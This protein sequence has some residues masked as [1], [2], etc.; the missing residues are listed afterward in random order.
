MRTLG[1]VPQQNHLGERAGEDESLN[2]VDLVNPV[3]YL[4]RARYMSQRLRTPVLRFSA[5]PT[6]LLE[7]RLVQR[8][9]LFVRDPMSDDEPRVGRGGLTGLEVLPEQREVE[10]AMGF[11]AKGRGDGEAVRRR[12]HHQRNQAALR[13][14]PHPQ[15]RRIL[16][17][18]FPLDL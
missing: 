18:G 12:R 4:P 3:Q 14:P 13:V 17:Y 6:H 9:G 10:R 15:R 2:H 8:D 7:V 1:G 11:L 16:R 5:P